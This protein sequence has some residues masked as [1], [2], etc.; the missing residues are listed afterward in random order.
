MTGNGVAQIVVF[1]LVVTALTPPLGAYISRVLESRRIP[2]VTRVLGPVERGIYRLLR[3]DPAR[4][5]GWKAYAGA[6][7]AFSVASFALLYVILRLQG[8]LPLNPSDYPGMSWYVAFN[9]AASFVTNTNW[10]FFVGRGDPLVPQPDGRARRAELRVGRRRHRGDGRRRARASRAGAPGR[11]ATSGPT[12]CASR[13][14]CWCRSPSSLGLVL[15]SQGVIQTFDDPVTYQTLEA[16]TLGTTGDDGQPVTQTIYR[17]PVASQIAIK[18]A[19]TN[20][21]GY[22]N[23]NSAVPFENPTPLT[24]YLE[25]VCR[26]HASPSRSPTPS[27]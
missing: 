18:H 11:S 12:S 27:G 17:G 10:Q 8:H 6:V 3:I 5:Q 19:G 2:G 21:G 4:E 25:L 14:T 16:R 1:L 20:G 23:S 26:D 13:S 7:L 15:G 24:N 22:Y 9:T